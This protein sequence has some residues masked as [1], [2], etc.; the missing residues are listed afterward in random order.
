MPDLEEKL[1]DEEE[2]HGEDELQ[3][4]VSGGLASP[5]ASEE[6]M[7]KSLESIR[8]GDDKLSKRRASILSK[9]RERDTYEHFPLDFIEYID[10][11][12]LSAAT[13]DEFALLRGKRE[14]ILYHG[15]RFNCHIEDHDLL[16]DALKSHK[17]RLEIHSH[18]DVEKITPSFDDRNFLKAIGQRKSKIISSYTGQIREFTDNEF[19]DL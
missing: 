3:Q 9:V 16:I 12:Y 4:E 11:A 8:H 15:T 18:P 7:R 5:L 1:W 10:L 13:G 6:S 14:D 17:L 19:E 2:V